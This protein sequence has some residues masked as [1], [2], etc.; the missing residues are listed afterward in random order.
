[1][2]RLGRTKGRLLVDS[3]WLDSESEDGDPKLGD[4]AVTLAA[5]RLWRKTEKQENIYD[6]YF[7]IQSNQIHKAESKFTS[8]ECGNQVF[9]DFEPANWKNKRVNKVNIVIN[10]DKHDKRF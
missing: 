8:A 1:M 4:A 7:F 6:T 3:H 2:F 9:W 10:T 5:Y